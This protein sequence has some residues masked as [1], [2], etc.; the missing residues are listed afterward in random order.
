MR[1]LGKSRRLL[2]QEVIYESRSLQL[3]LGDL[4][5]LEF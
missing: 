5:T 2:E 4:A 1:L 3:I